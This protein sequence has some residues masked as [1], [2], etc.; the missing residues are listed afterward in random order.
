ML[1]EVW[2]AVHWLMKPTAF[3]ASRS[4][5]DLAGECAILSWVMTWMVL[6]I[7]LTFSG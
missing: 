3:S 6:A 5:T 2:P 4:A 7:W 1:I